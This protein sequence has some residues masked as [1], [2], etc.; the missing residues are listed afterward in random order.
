MQFSH[1]EGMISIGVSTWVRPVICQASYKAQPPARNQITEPVG[2]W[3][4]LVIQKIDVVCGRTY[5]S[6]IS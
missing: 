1:H 4:K 6:G 3:V 2:H 5:D